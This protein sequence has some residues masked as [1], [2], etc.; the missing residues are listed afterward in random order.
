[1]AELWRLEDHIVLS[2]GAAGSLV[3]VEPFV[4]EWSLG[5]HQIEF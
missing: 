2:E 1:M 3:W 4:E 5:C